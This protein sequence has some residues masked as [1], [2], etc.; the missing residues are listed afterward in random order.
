MADWPA[1]GDT[2]WNAAMLAYLAVSFNTDGTPKTSV[3]GL[4]AATNEDSNGDTMLKAHAYKAATDGVVM[5][6]VTIGTAGRACRGYVGN[7]NDPAGAGTQYGVAVGNGTSGDEFSFIMEVPKNRYFEITL[8]TD[9]PTIYWRS[10]RALSKP[11][12]QD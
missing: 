2:N 10:R 3:F 8:A 7:T 1:D 4:S 9:T 12:D 6:V 5:V 11:V